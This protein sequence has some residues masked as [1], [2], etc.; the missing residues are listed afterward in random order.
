MADIAAPPAAAERRRRL[1]RVRPTPWA[2][3]VIVSAALLATGA[4]VLAI[5]WAVTKSTDSTSFTAQIPSLLTGVELDID[6]GDVE[7][8]GA[9][10]QEVLVNRVDYS[11]FGLGPDEKRFVT[12]GV[13]RIET[14]CPELVVGTCA[15]DYRITVPEEVPLMIRTE[16]GDVRLTAYRGSAVVSAE[17]GTVTVDAFCGTVL[18]VTATAGDIDVGAT[19]LATRLTLYTTSGDITLRVPPGRYSMDA[20]TISGQTTLRGVAD[21][22][23]A[24]PRIEA[25]SNSGD[26]SVE[27]GS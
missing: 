10:A 25:R 18:E 12:E 15:A 1:R 5:S 21:D 13:F 8:L 24:G 9:A 20:G 2:A 14:T 4:G 17:S 22:P 26:V 23:F 27:A 19:C 7:I 3:L 16:H 6:G 11:V